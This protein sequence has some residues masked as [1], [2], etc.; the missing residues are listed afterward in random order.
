MRAKEFLK[1]ADP[2]G[3]AM[4]FPGP[5]ELDDRVL[6]KAM[7]YAKYDAERF[8][9]SLYSNHPEDYEGQLEAII[10]E[11]IGDNASEEVREF[12]N[13][14]EIMTKELEPIIG[15][16]LKAHMMGMAEENSNRLQH[17]AGIKR[18]T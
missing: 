7:E 3:G 12:D 11:I 17:L 14:Y 1:E 8:D 10:D 9:V 18:I 4:T 15:P 16:K 2:Y 6:G 13:W 5:S